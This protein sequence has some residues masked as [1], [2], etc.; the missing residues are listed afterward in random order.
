MSRNPRAAVW[1]AFLPALLLS[2]CGTFTLD[3]PPDSKSASRRIYLNDKA[4]NDSL[5]RD[6]VR[7]GVKLVL[8]PGKDYDLTLEGT[9]RAND[10]LTV[11]YYNDGVSRLFQ[12]LSSAN[13][14][15]NEK[16]SLNSD[17]ITAQFFLAQL[18]PPDGN[19]AISSLHRVTLASAGIAGADTIH[20]RLLF[21][22]Q[23]RALPDSA[24]KAAFAA[25]LF[26]SMGKIYSPLGIVLKGSYDIVE[27]AV[28]AMVFPFSNTFVALPGNRVVGNAHLYM[29]D[30]ISIGDPNA[31]LAGDVL[32][33]APREVVDL[34]SHR[35]S[36]VVLSS[37][38]LRGMSANEAAASLAITATH[39]LGHFFGLRHTV[40]TLHDLLQD[41][42]YSNTED[43]FTDTRF[44]ALDIALAKTSA[45]A[46][47]EAWLKAMHSPYCLR[48]ADNSCSN[49][50]CD[51]LNLMYPVDCGTG[52]QTNLS[53]QQIGFL[54]QNLATY[55]H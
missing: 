14:G 15:T 40:S 17:Q 13:D 41:D 7:T 23:L 47:T 42:D 27:A 38:I 18:N 20:V 55:R 44:C 50:N 26:A 12:T 52:N 32:G 25:G 45:Q 8:Q 34:D 49:R 2:A 3:N 33:F 16:F 9:T 53:A 46:R 19:A 43:G 54:K 22:R 31:G 28:P 21:I 10:K 51:L 35:E 5:T 48:M 39:E 24:S 6:L 1:H 4:A 29:V 36:R 37:R 11:Y 30:S